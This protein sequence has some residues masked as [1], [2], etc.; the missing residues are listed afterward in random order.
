LILLSRQQLTAEQLRAAL[1]AQR[2]AGSGKIGEWLQRL[3]FAGEPQITAA[4]ARQ[5]SCPVLKYPIDPSTASRAAAIPVPLLE[6]FQMIPVDF[7]GNTGTLLIACSESVD[8][9]A[10]YAIEQM[11]GCRTEACFVASPILQKALRALAKSPRPR[12][13]IFD[14]AEDVGQDARTIARYVEKKHADQ[15]RL[16]RCGQ[17]I[18]I[19]LEKTGNTT[20]EAVNLLLP[21][22]A[23]T[24]YHAHEPALANRD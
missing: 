5:W 1:A 19:R 18:W 17:H 23:R 14:S 15:L 12:D 10:L 21:A 8:H 3:G 20:T 16:V 11:L 24:T 4:L 22:P 7:V 2:S 6:S 13:L 9:T